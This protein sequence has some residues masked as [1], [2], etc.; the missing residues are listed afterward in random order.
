MAEV[1]RFAGRE[2]PPESG[3]F[4]DAGLREVLGAL[5]WKFVTTDA[6]FSGDY[7]YPEDEEG[8]RE[9][10][11]RWCAAVWMHEHELPV[12]PDLAAFDL[13]DVEREARAYLDEHGDDAL[14]RGLT[15]EEIWGSQQLYWREPAALMISR[16][17][18]DQPLSRVGDLLM[19]G[20]SQALVFLLAGIFAGPSDGQEMLGVNV[21]VSDG[22]S[23]H[24]IVLNGLNTV[25]Y[26]HPRGDLVRA[27]WFSF[28]DPWPARS[29]LAPE[30]EYG[31]NVLEDVARPPFWLISPEDLDRILVGFVL[32]VRDLQRYA[33][34]FQL[35]DLAETAQ[36]Y[37][38]RPLWVEDGDRPDQPF[39]RMLD[40]V[41]WQT[42]TTRGT[43]EGLAR[44]QFLM[45]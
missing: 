36:K 3:P 18:S 45:G 1:L 24:T 42:R 17:F 16:R 34:L 39:A 9:E 20:D 2:T 12:G 26:Q 4:A 41:H 8:R 30:R 5:S 31:V 21:L 35:L 7:V 23:G 10:L 37:H 38:K 14:N 43:L 32:S 28:H 15:L 27:G 22:R 29:L 11:A 44:L 13:F 40:A 25:E 19:L 6:T 33:M